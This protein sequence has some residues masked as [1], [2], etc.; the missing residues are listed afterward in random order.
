M[1]PTVDDAS[2]SEKSDDSP[3]PTPCL[4]QAAGLRCKALQP[5]SVAD[6]ACS[7]LVLQ[8]ASPD[9]RT[10]EQKRDAFLALAQEVCVRSHKR[11]ACHRIT[12]CASLACLSC[13]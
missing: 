9:A 12:D 3:L 7:S 11:C 5:E 10:E 13:I 8:R 2:D 4:M 1:L 6:K